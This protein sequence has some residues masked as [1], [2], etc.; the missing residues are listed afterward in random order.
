MFTFKITI[1]IMI[2]STPFILKNA[3]ILSPKVAG[4]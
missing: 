3:R 1:V 4:L 2:Q